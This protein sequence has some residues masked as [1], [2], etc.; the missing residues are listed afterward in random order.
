MFMAMVM[1]CALSTPGECVRFD[2][3]R[4]PYPQRQQCVV[5][6]QEM[7]VGIAKMFPVPATYSFKCKELTGT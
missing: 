4:G 6:S 2:D 3:T 7:A 1:V 5:R